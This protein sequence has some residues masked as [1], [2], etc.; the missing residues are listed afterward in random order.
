MTSI[1]VGKSPRALW[2]ASLALLILTALSGLSAGAQVLMQP[3]LSAAQAQ[4]IV[5]TIIAECS[6]PGDL[7]T[8]TVAVVDRAGQPIMQ[9]RADTASPHNYEL[10]FRKA[11]TARTFRR[12]SIVFRDQTAGGAVNVGQ[13]SLS[14]IIALGG[15][16]PIMLGEVPIGGVGVSGAAGGQAADTVCAEAGIAAIADELE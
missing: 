2:V 11:Y 12:T 3:N 5:A 1:D 16:V 10:A 13:R 14:N 8:V 6:L 7:L 15:G 4:R 9:L